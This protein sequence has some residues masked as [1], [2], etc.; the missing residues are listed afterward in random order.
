[1][2]MTTTQHP[3]TPVKTVPAPLKRCAIVGTAGTWRQTP[4]HDTGRLT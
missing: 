4:W 2:E 1:M 3:T